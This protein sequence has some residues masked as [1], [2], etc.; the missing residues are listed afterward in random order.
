[1]FLFLFCDFQNNMGR[2]G[3]QRLVLII[4]SFV[5]KSHNPL[6]RH[7][8]VRCICPVPYCKNTLKMNM[9]VKMKACKKQL[10]FLHLLFTCFHVY[11]LVH[12]LDL[13]KVLMKTHF[14]PHNFPVQCNFRKVNC[15][16]TVRCENKLKLHYTN[17]KPHR[18]VRCPGQTH[19][20][21]AAP[22]SP[23]YLSGAPK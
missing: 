1:M 14:A 6:S 2:S 7:Q 4:E 19:D 20:P 3:F 17:A 10:F 13:F 12:F 22:D 11:K 16:W 9:F 8:T 15:C 21:A 18:T 23:V 5:L